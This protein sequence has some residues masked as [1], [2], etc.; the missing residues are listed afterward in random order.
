MQLIK[1]TI[2][3]LDE[4]P[5]SDNVDSCE[6]EATDICAAIEHFYNINTGVIVRIDAPITYRMEAESNANL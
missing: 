3:Y 4:Y 2:H 5:L 1:Y 6:I